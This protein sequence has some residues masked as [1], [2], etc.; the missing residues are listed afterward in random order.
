MIRSFSWFEPDILRQSSRPEWPVMLHN[1]CFLHAAIQLRARFGQGGWN[2]PQDFFNIGYSCLQVR[3]HL[4]T[5]M[6]TLD[7]CAHAIIN[8]RF[9][10]ILIKD[11][12]QSTCFQFI[13]AIYFQNMK[14][15]K[16]KHLC[17]FFMKVFRS[18]DSLIFFLQ[19]ALAIVQSEFKEPL[20]S[21]A[22]DGS[23]NSRSVSY[24]GIRYMVAE[25][26]M[27]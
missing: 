3:P 2:C 13:N 18:F 17:S 8:G 19:E 14:K 12:R 6:T 25:V 5:G 21:V 1:L 16:E 23:Q 4:F 7:R 20:T 11:D 15:T 27:H 10:I 9:T 22:P 24:N 26:C